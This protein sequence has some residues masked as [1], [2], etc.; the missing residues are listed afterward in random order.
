[1]QTETCSLGTIRKQIRFCVGL[2]LL[3]NSETC[4]LTNQGQSALDADRFDLVV[5][6][7]VLGYLEKNDMPWSGIEITIGNLDYPSPHQIYIELSP[8]IT[9]DVFRTCLFLLS[10]CGE[11]MDQNVLESITFKIYLTEEKAKK[12]RR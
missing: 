7:A 11:E 6:Q 1:M 10:Q 8:S 12:I 5:Q 3:E 4:A 9:E 2:G